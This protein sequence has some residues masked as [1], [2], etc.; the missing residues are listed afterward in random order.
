M[1]EWFKLNCPVRRDEKD[2]LEYGLNWLSDQF[3]IERL[4]QCRVILPT[5]HFFPDVYDGSYNAV[6]RIL[7]RVCHYM[8]VAPAEVSLRLYDGERESG[9]DADPGLPILTEGS[10]GPATFHIGRS[11]VISIEQ[12][13]RNDPMLL[14]AVMAHELCHHILSAPGVAPLDEHEEEPMTD[15]ATVFMGMGVFSANS[16][17]READWHQ[18]DRTAW[19][20]HAG[21][22]L[23]E[24][25]FAYAL[26][27][28]AWERG[29]NKPPW[30]RHLRRPV[31]RTFRTGVKYL[32]KTGDT[33]F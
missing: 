18:G 23:S 13:C 1:F 15:L 24:R 11:T 5:D 12:S 33:S 4:R 27:L 17:I 30:A 10:A 2:W 29:E 19:T 8:E 31:R 32:L 22:Y 28:F 25:M 9:L 21:G 16:V 20:I 6:R 3:E 7:I 14:V 26:S